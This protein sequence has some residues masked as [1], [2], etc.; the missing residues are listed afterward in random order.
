[1]FSRFLVAI[2]L[3][4]ILI[5]RAVLSR[6]NPAKVAMLRKTLILGT[7]RSRFLQALADTPQVLASAP[8][9]PSRN[10]ILV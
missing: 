5:P 1:M 2:R 4:A 7:T 8:R 6:D 9:S 10:A 3:P